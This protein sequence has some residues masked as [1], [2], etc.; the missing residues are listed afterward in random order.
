M[1]RPQ[2]WGEGPEDGCEPTLML[3]DSGECAEHKSGKEG[4]SL[5]MGSWVAELFG[6]FPSGFFSLC[7]ILV[8]TKPFVQHDILI[9]SHSHFL[10]SQFP[11]FCVCMVCL[12]VCLFC[13]MGLFVTQL[14]WEHSSYTAQFSPYRVPFGGCQYP[15]RRMHVARPFQSISITSTRA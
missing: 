13:T 2:L 12:F 1:G 11:C 5:I 10:F 8:E 6:W 4:G 15:R 3:T 9:L 7:V 14:H